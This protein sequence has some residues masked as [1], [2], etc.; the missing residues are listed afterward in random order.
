MT[1][2][3][4]NKNSVN[5]TIYTLHIDKKKSFLE[6]NSFKIKHKLIKKEKYIQ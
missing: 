4:K 2:L 3:N 6:K 1:E 5:Q